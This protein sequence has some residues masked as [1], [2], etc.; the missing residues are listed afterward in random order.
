MARLGPKKSQRYGREEFREG[1]LRPP[2]ETPRRASRATLVRQIRW[3]Q[4]LEREHTTIR[5]HARHVRPRR[6]PGAHDSQSR[7]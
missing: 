5:E 2:D 7:P 6:A 3:L 1:H 4:D